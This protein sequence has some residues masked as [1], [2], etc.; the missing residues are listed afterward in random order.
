MKKNLVFC[1][2]FAVLACNKDKFQTVPQITIK[3]INTD[4]VDRNNT[5]RVILE[6]TDKEGDVSDS[7]LVVRV[8]LNR[9]SP[10]RFPLPF[11]IPSFPNTSKG[12][13][14][15]DFDY[16]SALT[17]ASNPI[18]IPGSVPAS[19]EPDTLNLKFVARDKAGNKSDTATATVIVI[20]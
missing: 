19:N 7:I 14:Q 5:L 4:I 10:T 13:F 6:Y 12:E 17:L 1:L 20:R 8:R 3:S 16:N 2:L 11:K 15:V 18:R 9:K